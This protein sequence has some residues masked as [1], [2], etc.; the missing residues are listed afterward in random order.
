MMREISSKVYNHI[1][2]SAC[3]LFLKKGFQKTTMREIADAAN[4]S[5]GLVAYYFHSKDN[6][7]VAFYSIMRKKCIEYV[8][9]HVD[10]V[11]D[12]YSYLASLIYLEFS[13]NT[14]PEFYKLYYDF[15]A[16]GIYEKYVLSSGTSIVEKIANKEGKSPSQDELLLYSVFVCASIE[17]TLVINKE[18]GLFPSIDFSD[19]PEYIFRNSVRH[20]LDNEQTISHAVDTAK[21]LI[22]SYHTIREDFSLDSLLSCPD[23]EK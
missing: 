16:T 13:V 21:K 15:L 18:I 1:L 8:N 6:I 10:L 3:S 9:V 4:V 17:K 19:I 7:P 23:E 11:N 14:L 12:P 22:A 5:V 20:I 2:Y